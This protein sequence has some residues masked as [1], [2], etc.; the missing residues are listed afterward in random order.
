MDSEEE[1]A[2]FDLDQVELSQSNVQDIEMATQSQPVSPN[3][4]RSPSPAVQVSPAP[5]QPVSPNL[6]QF[7]TSSTSPVPFPFHS[8][9]KKRK[10]DSLMRDA[11]KRVQT[12]KPT[13]THR[14]THSK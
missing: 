1:G 10:G 6:S 14:S 4:S 11:L 7:P 13:T 3:P 2:S 5:S 9:S 12:N 8:L